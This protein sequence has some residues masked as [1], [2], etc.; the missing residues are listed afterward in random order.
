LI[1]AKK[2]HKWVRTVGIPVVEDGK[3]VKVRGFFQDITERKKVELSIAQM[4]T[5]LEKRVE[6]RTKELQLKNRELETFSYT[7]SHDLKAPLRGIAGYSNLLLEGNA[8]QLD[9][10][11]KSYLTKL[12]GSAN[13]MEKLI[14]DLLTYS[15][16]ERRPLIR[17]EVSLQELIDILI[18]EH[19]VEIK[20]RDIKIHIEI[21]NIVVKTDQDA[22]GFVL[23][24]VIDNSLKF[25]KLQKFP[26]IRVTSL[27]EDTKCIIAIRDNGIGFDMKYH[28]KI[29][30]IFQRLNL[31]EDYPGTGVGLAI[32]RKSIERLGGTIWAES[33][34][35]NGATFFI[36][37]PR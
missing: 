34:P 14:E 15:R 24:N 33:E 30:Q 36:S 16:E 1:S 18:E 25:T 23:R 6:E 8:N 20:Q 5:E 31:S 19:S 35:G 37:I 3:V 10:D 29:Y 17:N 11:G 22:L 4:N 27:L 21:E 28:E 32:A 13:R 26:E 9:E 12:I 7:V 2:V